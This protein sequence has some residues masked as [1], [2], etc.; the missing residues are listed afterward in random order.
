MV[1]GEAS[2]DL[3]GAGLMQSLQSMVPHVRFIG[4]GG[5]K[6]QALGFESLFPMERLAVMGITEVVK[7]L[8][9]LLNIR[10][11]IAGY[12]A[13]YR[14]AL[15]VGID[16]PDFNLDLEHSLHKIGIKTVHYVS[17]SVWAWRQDRVY[18]IKKSVD[19]ILTLFPFEAEFYRKHGVPVTFVGHPLADELPLDVDQAAARASLNIEQDRPVLAVMPGSRRG[20]IEHIGPA[21]IR[22][23]NRIARIKRE[24]GQ[25]Y[26]FCIPSVNEKRKAQIEQ[27]ARTILGRH[28]G[29]GESKAPS[30]RYSVGDARDVMAASDA[31]LLASGTATLEAMLLKRPMVAAYKWGG[32]THAIISRMVKSPYVT[33]PNLLANKGLVSELIQERCHQRAI[34]PELE[35][36]LAPEAVKAVQSEFTRLHET[37]RQ[38][39]SQK[40]AE[41][42]LALL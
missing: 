10:K 26:L 9:E 17:P 42:V 18:K 20:E 11:R 32:I 38:G 40:A 27:I 30:I 31:V 12:F 39:A 21:F 36:A 35:R 16:A 24:E 1:V 7:R 2:G 23:I 25:A 8:P 5:P 6:M 4:I 3:L 14:P 41:A 19:R 34:V 22:S 29:D 15:F 37:L 33:L 28:G 13:N